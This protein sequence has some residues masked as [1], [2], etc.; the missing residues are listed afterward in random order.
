MA[1]LS[2]NK[3]GGEVVTAFFLAAGDDSAGSTNPPSP[4]PPPPHPPTP[5]RDTPDI[6]FFTGGHLV[7]TGSTLLDQ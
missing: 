1:A 5:P 3:W 7:R 4:S 6:F 2:T